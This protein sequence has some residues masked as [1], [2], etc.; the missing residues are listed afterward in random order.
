MKLSPATLNDGFWA[1]KGY[2]TPAFDVGEVR[3]RTRKSPVW[4]HFGVGNIFRVFPA[5][6]QQK[7]LNAGLARSGIVGCEV[8]DEECVTKICDRY[9]CLT[10]G[11]TLRADGG[12]DKDVIA[13][14]TDAYTWSA[15][16]AKVAE[17][18]EN[19]SLQ[20]ASFTITE[21]GYQLKAADGSLLP[22]IA[23]DIEA[24]P[25]HAANLMGV[26]AGLLHRRYL[27]GAP[28]VTL[29]SLDN[30]SHNGD[31]LYEAVN[32]IAGEWLARGMVGGGFL[33]YLND[34]S[35]TAFPISMIDKIT[36]RPSGAVRDMLAADGL[37]DCDIVVTARNTY[38]A[39]FVN[40]EETGYLVVEDTFPGGRPP[41]EKAG[42]I[43]TDRGTVNKVEKMK[44]CTCLNPL[45]SAL[46]VFGCLLGY[47][48]IAAE[49]KDAE[50][51]RLISRIGYDEGLPVAVDPGIISPRAFIGECI[52]VRFPNAFVPDT[53][54]RIAC[55][56]SQKIPV[57]FGET[58]KAYRSRGLDTA[59]LRYIPLFFAGYLKY[60]TGIGDDGGPFELSPDP[61]LD[62]LTGRLKG[63]SAQNLHERVEP[64]LSNAMIF[65]LNLYECGLGGKVEGYFAR[66]LEGPGAVRAA[67]KESL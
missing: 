62:E 27:K 2:K 66:M 12:A 65:G 22:F 52:N 59:S 7:L 29:V 50:L 55:D 39:A 15:G 58:L 30:C 21:K 8:F 47:T 49:M 37:E 4:L 36:P 6:M 33:E 18:F 14:L 61:M 32:F 48:S 53:P 60:L 63:I 23:G 20:M 42:A 25:D 19:P 10:V 64:I 38:T 35:K 45:H 34:R 16:R 43:F 24:G 41:L 40:S 51:V 1:Q 56:T 5:M 26:T 13:G 46:A 67:L 11:V 54:Q 17:I 57:R 44:V 31:R 9:G 3:E 28:P